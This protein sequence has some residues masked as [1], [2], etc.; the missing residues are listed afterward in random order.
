MERPGYIYLTPTPVRIWH[1]INALGIVTLCITGA[2]IRF[3][4]YVTIFGS[5]KATIL[6]HD[7]AGIAVSISYLLWLFYYLVIAGTMKKLYI[8]TLEDLK[9]GAIRQAKFYGYYFFTGGPNPH[10]C[11]P[12]CKFNPMQK[13][14]YM[15]IMMV[16]VPLIIV[17]GLL[18]L[19][20][21][22]LRVWIMAIGGIKILVGI[23]FLIAC[24]LCAFLFVHVYLATMGHTPIA[25]FKP[26]WH[27]WEEIEEEHGE[28]NAHQPH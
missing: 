19:N 22:P 27:G 11:T 21:D 28:G 26:M 2:Q 18:L 5:Y 1:W 20:V 9:S 13:A 25:H 17:S 10:H 15:M 24:A 7:T 14:G 12:D 23:H 3:P 16:L 8:P 6:L 4:E